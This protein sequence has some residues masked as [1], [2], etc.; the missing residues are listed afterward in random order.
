MCLYAL[1]NNSER[2]RRRPA[3]AYQDTVQYLVSRHERFRV[4]PSNALRT[5]TQT[6]AGPPPPGH[7]LADDHDDP[8]INSQK[9]F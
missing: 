1:I 6:N 3:S 4:T 5:I 9:G 8:V 2:V 7:G